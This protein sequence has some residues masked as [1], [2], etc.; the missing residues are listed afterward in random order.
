MRSSTSSSNDRLPRGGWGRT[1]A[2]TA[3]LVLGPLT[4]W[5]VWWRSRGFLSSVEAADESWIMALHQVPAATAVALG[6]SRIQAALDPE[7]LQREIGGRPAIDL[8][9]PGNSPIPLLE[10]LADSVRYA[11]LVIV[12][13][14]PLYAF[15]AEQSGATRAQILIQRY[16]RE[17]VSPARLTENWLEVHLLSPF[18]FRKAQLLPARLVQTL[19]A[20]EP[21]E[22]HPGRMRPNRFMP[23]DQ[24]RYQAKNGWDSVSGFHGMTYPGVERPGRPANDAE[25][26]ALKGRILGATNRILD[27]GGQVV[28]L[29]MAA[30]GERRRIEER[31][32]PRARYWDPLERETRAIAIATEDY[33]ELSR[34]ACWDGSHIDAADAPAW[35]GAFG[36]IIR[37]RIRTPSPLR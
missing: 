5:E 24:R 31:R 16:G 30:C 29:Y 13:I 11:G 21:I 15:D 9:L 12:E 25:Y 8:A 28:L 14:L 27:R 37:S 2:L 35:A 34:F 1:W 10:Y 26:A 18:V 19:R 3:L 20:G 7:A 33:P 4:T 32:Y 36:R 17:R 6:T 23:I 22:P